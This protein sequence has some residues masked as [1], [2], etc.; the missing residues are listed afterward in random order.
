MN[1]DNAP[2][3]SNERKFV[4]FFLRT[5]MSEETKKK[6]YKGT[7]YSMFIEAYTAASFSVIGSRRAELMTYV[8]YLQTVMR[9]S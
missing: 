2:K 9:G 5:K 4:A 6:S 1:P 7:T 8:R 3:T